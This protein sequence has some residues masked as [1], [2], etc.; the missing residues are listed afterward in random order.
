MLKL[1]TLMPAQVA[2][3][4][5]KKMPAD[6]AGATLKQQK[7]ERKQLAAVPVATAGKPTAGVL[8]QSRSMK[9]AAVMQAP[10]AVAATAAAVP[11]VMVVAAGT[12]AL[13]EAPVAAQAAAVDFAAV[14]KAF[15]S[16]KSGR[17]VAAAQAAAAALMKRDLRLARATVSGGSGG[18]AAAAPRFNAFVVSGGKEGQVSLVCVVCGEPCL[19]CLCRRQCQHQRGEA[20]ASPLQDASALLPVLFLAVVCCWLHWAVTPHAI[21]S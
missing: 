1:P 5:P 12:R 14:P 3:A 2:A 13:G 11:P 10:S 20:A 9:H 8:A 15:S 19:C 16:L 7:A 17:S 4:H 21:C 18:C 6:A